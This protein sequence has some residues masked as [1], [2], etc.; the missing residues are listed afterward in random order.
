MRK[1]PSILFLLLYTGIQTGMLAWDY[2]QPLAHFICYRLNRPG[3]QKSK[4]VVIKID[5]ATYKSSLRDDREIFWQGDLY[6]IKQ[7]TV[8]GHT[9]ELM[10]EK[11]DLENRWMTLYDNLQRHI[12]GSRSRHWPERREYYQWLL[13]LYLPAAGVK[14]NQA[15]VAFSPQGNVYTISRLPFFSAEGPYRPPESC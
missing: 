5:Y 1:L 15:P 14:T 3:P 7:V 8:T 6:D 9:V 13:K 11:D 2:Y 12:A 4:P 10:A